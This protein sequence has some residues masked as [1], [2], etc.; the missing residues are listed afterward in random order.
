MKYFDL[1]LP[2]SPDE[3]HPKIH[4]IS[5]EDFKKAYHDF[6]RELAE[7]LVEIGFGKWAPCGVNGV[8]T[9][10]QAMIDPMQLF[11][12]ILPTHAVK[13]IHV[14]DLIPGSYP[15][16]GNMTAYGENL[17]KDMR[18]SHAAE[19]EYDAEE[20][21]TSLEDDGADDGADDALKA[22]VEENEKPTA[23]PDE[24]KEELVKTSES[25]ADP[26]PDKK[27]EKKED[28]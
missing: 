21:D 4:K 12:I 1:S 28:K 17:I 24:L 2:E 18:F 26:K 3:A 9:V 14:G 8:I 10:P 5:F 7:R 16:I 13:A 20:Y 11:F 25:K 6:P 23:K 19:D 22:K 15:E 27:A